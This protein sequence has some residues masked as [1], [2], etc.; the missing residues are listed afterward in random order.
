MQAAAVAVQAVAVAVQAVAVQAV[1]VV[2]QLTQL[3]GR[4]SAP[5]EGVL[6]CEA[7]ALVLDQEATASRTKADQEAAA[8]VSS[9]QW[10]V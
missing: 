8:G 9:R 3:T 7:Q 2:K 10:L 4:A 1:A 5:K 6:G